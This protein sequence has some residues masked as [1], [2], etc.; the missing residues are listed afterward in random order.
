MSLVVPRPRQS[1]TALTPRRG[2]RNADDAAK[3]INLRN[4]RDGVDVC[5][6]VMVRNIPNKMD[7]TSRMP[8]RQVK[9]LAEERLSKAVMLLRKSRMRRNNLQQHYAAV[10]Q[11]HVAE[12]FTPRLVATLRHPPVALFKMTEC[13]ALHQF[14]DAEEVYDHDWIGKGIK[15]LL[16][17]P[18]RLKR[19]HLD[20]SYELADVLEDQF[21]SP[22]TIPQ[23]TTSQRTPN[24]NVSRTGG[25]RYGR[26]PSGLPPAFA[27]PAVPPL[28][29]H[30][31]T[32]WAS[33]VAGSLKLRLSFCMRACLRGI[34]DNDVHH[35][36]RKFQSQY[37]RRLLLMEDKIAY[38]LPIT[39]ITMY[40]QTSDES[41]LASEQLWRFAKM[42][43]RERLEVSSGSSQIMRQ[44]Y[45]GTLV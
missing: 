39:V 22:P 8:R 15:S 13:I 26:A 41:Q 10:I 1:T 17:A 38:S 4:I 25:H 42:A 2:G 24:S 21:H 27:T 40:F 33:A 45:A 31:R 12:I 9:D 29:H 35:F 30:Q 34:E 28:H 36:I 23:C 20:G 11:G 43:T 19:L 37:Q 6:T 14:W 7:T 18:A 5:T 3:A 16:Q 44:P 32:E